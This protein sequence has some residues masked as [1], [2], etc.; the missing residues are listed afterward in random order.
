MLQ[1]TLFYGL[2]YFLCVDLS[3]GH[4]FVGE[5]GEVG[6]V[7]AEANRRKPWT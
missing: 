3:L 4:G 5:V 7:G 1:L 6:A 2:F